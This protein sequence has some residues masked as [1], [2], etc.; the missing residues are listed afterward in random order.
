MAINPKNQA[1]RNMSI[2]TALELAKGYAELGEAGYSDLA[3]AFEA[4]MR[5]EGD[6]GNSVT[7]RAVAA[8]M[9]FSFAIEIYLKVLS[10]QFT[11]TYSEG[12]D[13][14]MLVD[15]LPNAVVKKIT[16][17]YEMQ[18]NEKINRLKINVIFTISVN[19]TP[20]SQNP[21]TPIPHSLDEWPGHTFEEAISLAAPLFVKLR[22]LYENIADELIT[23]IDFRWLT[24]L[25]AAIRSQLN[26]FEAA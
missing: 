19:G 6:I 16:D 13:L 3:E 5:G 8:A 10:F 18:V 12:H 7:M 14:A 20:T 23:E 24:F 4:N 11:G 9:V 2:L 17:R 25:L 1:N 26:E 21:Y 22:Y 15:A